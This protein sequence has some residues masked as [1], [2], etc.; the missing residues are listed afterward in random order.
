[1]PSGG[2]TVKFNLPDFRRQLQEVGRRVERRVT[3]RA[4][5]AAARVFR[6]DA[7]RTAPV[8]KEP[9]PGRVA[10]ALRRAIY[11]GRSKFQKRGTVRFFVGVRAA[12]KARK[13]ARDP[14]YWRFLEGGW[15]PR[16]AGRAL[17]GGNRSKALQR[18][19]AISS[20]ARKV[21][22]PFLKPAFDR[23]QQRAVQAFS[24]TMEERLEREIK[25]VR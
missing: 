12:K 22:Y 15:I 18:K 17:R 21:A 7:R 24:Q 5:G 23:S 16:G 10:G 25:G 11:A 13:T 19:R 4:V 1:M 20:G 8:L 2:V 3:V 9:R 14:F 6:D